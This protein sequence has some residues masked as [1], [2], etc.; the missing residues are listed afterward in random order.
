MR[1]NGGRAAKQAENY[2]HL[3]RSQGGDIP[4]TPT[5][6]PDP[7]QVNGQA[8]THVRTPDGNENFVP[9][10]ELIRRP[11]KKASPPPG[12]S[13]ADAERLTSWML[14]IADQMLGDR[15]E[16]ANGSCRF[17]ANRSLV[18]HPG[19]LFHNFVTGKSGVG[20]LALL[21]ALHDVNADGA[22]QWAR[23]WLNDHSGV[24]GL[25]DGNE[26]AQQAADE[27]TAL[28]AHQFKTVCDPCLI[29]RSRIR[30][31]SSRRAGL[32]LCVP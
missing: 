12:L 9:S 5:G 32:M 8:F 27:V 25:A 21:M 7:P 6:E 16:E 19:G 30:L 1:F 4:C 24:G 22:V 20:G 23:A 29:L 28:A 13:P 14:H 15:Q 31:S 11:A 17:G 3:W 26:E 2:T 18:I 10:D